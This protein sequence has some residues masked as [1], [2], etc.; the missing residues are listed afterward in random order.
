MALF[1]LK[2]Q[3][4]LQTPTV[5][6]H[7]GPGA[8]SGLFL[9]ALL[10]HGS[11]AFQ[12]QVILH[13]QPGCGFDTE[14]LATY[15][16]EN[17]CVHL[18]RDL[19]SEAKVHLLAESFGCTLALRFALVF[20]SKVASLTLVGPHFDRQEAQQNIYARAGEVV[21][22]LREELRTEEYVLL[23]Q[24]LRGKKEKIQYRESSSKKR[25]LGKDLAL[26]VWSPEKAQRFEEALLQ[27]LETG[28]VSEFLRESLLQVMEADLKVF[29]AEDA[30]QTQV[31]TEALKNLVK[32]YELFFVSSQTFAEVTK[33]REDALAFPG[34]PYTGESLDR[35]CKQY[36]TDLETA[37]DWES[38]NC[39]P[40]V[41][42]V[43]HQ[44]IKV[45]VVT[46]AQDPFATG[47]NYKNLLER[48][49]GYKAYVMDQVGHSPIYEKPEMTFELLESVLYGK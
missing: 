40:W 9:G 31:S 28:L 35:S 8:N 6:I 24:L 12:S 4:G 32:R 36:A 46:G 33:C 26:K 37:T 43:L 29:A 10:R 13:D 42:E 23:P 17:L 5:F 19:S 34:S 47:R 41:E 1:S 14:G 30:D 25:P 2:A 44:G 3:Q 21:L 20:P 16:F 45:S 18:G 38:R 27:A 7:G 15:N 49:E 11:E 22:R 48:H 39:W